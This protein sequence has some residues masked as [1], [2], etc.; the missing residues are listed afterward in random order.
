MELACGDEN[1]FARL[2]ACKR[3]DKVLNVG[4]SAPVPSTSFHSVANDVNWNEHASLIVPRA[5]FDSVPATSEPSGTPLPMT[6]I[7]VIHAPKITPA[8]LGS[9][10]QRIRK[11][12]CGS[13]PRADV[14]NCFR[15]GGTCGA[16]CRLYT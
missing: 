7:G 6:A 12:V 14:K 5:R 16:E 15:S 1:A 9:S 3:A 11:T 4:T 10:A 2:F 8:F 13:G